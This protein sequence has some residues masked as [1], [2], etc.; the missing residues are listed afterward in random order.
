AIDVRG[1]APLLQVFDMPTSIAF[2]RDVLGFEVVATS[3]PGKERFGWA[4]LRLNGLELMLNTA[5]EDDERPPAPDPARVAAHNDT[6]IYFS[7]P[8]VDAAYADLRKRGV[9]VK[10]PRIAPY[11]MKQM[12][13]SDPDGYELC[14]QWA[15]K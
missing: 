15:A 11:G 7:C 12:Y 6:S 1:L 9:K 14:F 13:V 2:Y 8:D 10:E 5:Y 4:L 3:Q